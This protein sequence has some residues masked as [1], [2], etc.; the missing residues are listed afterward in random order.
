M[1][2]SGPIGGAGVGAAMLGSYGAGGEMMGNNVRLPDQEQYSQLI[3]GP[4]DDMFDVP[5]NRNR[6]HVSRRPAPQQM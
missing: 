6:N 4:E 3:G 2:G 5:N 1:Y